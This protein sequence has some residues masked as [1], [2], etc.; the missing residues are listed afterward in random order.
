VSILNSPSQPPGAQAPPPAA[1]RGERWQREAEYFNAIEYSAAPIHPLTIQRY[2]EC[3]RPWLSAEHP[4]WAMGDVA[5]KRI[6]DIGCGDG[7]RSI[8]LGLKGAEVLGAD[9]SEEAIEAARRRAS[10]HGVANRVHFHCGPLEDFAPSG[11]FDVIAGWNILHHLIPE[12]KNFLDGIQRFGNPDCL[13]VFYEPVNLSAALRRLRVALPVP[14]EG[15]PDERPLEREELDIVRSV[16]PEVRVAYFNFFVRLFSRFV[17]G[18]AGYENAPPLK[19]RLHEAFGRMD[20]LLIQTCGL[21]GL[22]STAAI[23]CR[24][25]HPQ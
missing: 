1:D 20:W 18:N 17:L 15:T 23:V 16:F 12:L 19:R 4:F 3:R 14:V 25:R 9:L 22:S 10:V 8:L 7:T 5:G 2:R 24:R 11:K 6:L 21:R 13:Y